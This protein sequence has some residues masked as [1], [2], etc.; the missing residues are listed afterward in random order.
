MKTQNTT[1]E[2]LYEAIRQYLIELKTIGYE[3][4]TVKRS[5]Q[6]LRKKAHW[7]NTVN[8]A[9]HYIDDYLY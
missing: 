9:L 1:N 3:K 5:L 2:L 8:K 7:S 4:E 6:K